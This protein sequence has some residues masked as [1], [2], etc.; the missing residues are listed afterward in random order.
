[1]PVKY[2]SNIDVALKFD[3]NSLD[4]ANAPIYK[5]LKKLPT[6]EGLKLAQLARKLPN[7]QSILA[8]FTSLHTHPR[9][10]KQLLKDAS[11]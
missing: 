5:L 11:P 8:K 6:S 9:N 10:L 3:A 4:A 2:P 7:K 1:M